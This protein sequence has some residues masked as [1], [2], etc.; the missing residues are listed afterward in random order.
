LRTTTFVAGRDAAAEKTAR[1]MSH[2]TLIIFICCCL[3][4]IVALFERPPVE[5]KTRP[6]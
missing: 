1:T 4:L 5:K 3:S 6:R 2:A